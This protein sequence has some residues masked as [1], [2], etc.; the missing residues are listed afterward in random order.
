M[1][2]SLHKSSPV[3]NSTVTVTVTVTVTPLRP[4]HKAGLRLTKLHHQRAA[5]IS[6]RGY[7]A[8]PQRSVQL[9]QISPSTERHHLQTP[10]QRRTHNAGATITRTPLSQQLH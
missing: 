2:F 3:L 9:D 6:R 5:T 7:H 10:H 8:P 1:T 4:F